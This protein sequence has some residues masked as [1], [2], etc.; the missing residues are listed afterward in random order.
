MGSVAI[1]TGLTVAGIAAALLLLWPRLARAPMWR[2]T[3]TPLA[4]IIGSGFLILGPILVDSFGSL[5]VLAMAALCFAGYAFGAAI[6]FNIAQIAV[7]HREPQQIARGEQMASWALAFA[8]VIS[9]AYYLNLLGAF[10]TR[11]FDHPPAELPRII[12][13]LA[14]GVILASGLWRGFGLLERLE[15]VSVSIKLAIIAA[16]LGALVPLR[17]STG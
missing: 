17:G 9:V 3:I 12:T 11:L 6:R 13:T 10:A 16:L 4:S 2:A 5:A 15:Q 7:H 14:Y 1:E 8:Y